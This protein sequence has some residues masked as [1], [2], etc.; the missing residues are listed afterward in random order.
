MRYAAYKLDGA[1]GGELRDQY[2]PAAFSDVSHVSRRDDHEHE[3]SDS[4]A[5]R[6]LFHRLDLYGHR[7]AGRYTEEGGEADRKR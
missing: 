6:N 1:G 5:G 3:C 7:H 4:G 2:D